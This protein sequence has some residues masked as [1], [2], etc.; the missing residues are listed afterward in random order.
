MA[1]D[2]VVLRS[3]AVRTG[4]DL[5]DATTTHVHEHRHVR[6]RPRREMSTIFDVPITARV[7]VVRRATWPWET[8]CR[9]DRVDGMRGRDREVEHCAN[10]AELTPV[11]GLVVQ[12]PRPSVLYSVPR[13]R[14]HLVHA[15]MPVTSRRTTQD[16]PR[17]LQDDRRGPVDVV[18]ERPAACKPAVGRN[19][20][21]G[22]TARGRH[23]RQREQRHPDRR[24]ATTRHRRGRRRGSRTSTRAAPSPATTNPAMRNGLGPRVPLTRGWAVSGSWASGEPKLLSALMCKTWRPAVVGVAVRLRRIKRPPPIVGHRPKPGGFSIS[25]PRS[26]LGTTRTPCTGR[27]PRL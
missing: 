5:D 17:T 4:A 2:R 3:V 10:D 21:R 19:R 7:P 23:E 9:N 11:A 6:Q 12:L 22:L 8:G 20:R 26:P 14:E 16:L 24:G 1:L 25:S 18:G 15:R 27:E 13:T